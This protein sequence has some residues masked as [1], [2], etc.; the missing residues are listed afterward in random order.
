MLM[1]MEV[2]MEE[3]GL[4]GEGGRGGIRGGGWMVRGRYGDGGIEV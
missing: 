2:G 1:G 4:V 3:G